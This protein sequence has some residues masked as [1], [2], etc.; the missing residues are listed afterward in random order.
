MNC[1]ILF[2]IRRT[3]RVRDQYILNVTQRK[4][5]SEALLIKQLRVLG[6]WLRRPD[7]ATIRMYVLYTTN[8]GKNRRGR[9]CATYVKSMQK[10]IGMGNE[11]LMQLAEDREEW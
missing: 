1:R 6:H 5:L 9:P 3:D 4:K 8:Q 10:V 2:N 11:T 7:Y